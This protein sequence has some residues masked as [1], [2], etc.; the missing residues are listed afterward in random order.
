MWKRMIDLEYLPLGHSCLTFLSWNDARRNFRNH[1]VLFWALLHLTFPLK[2]IHF[3]HATTGRDG[4]IFIELL[5]YW[6]AQL[7][8][9]YDANSRWIQRIKGRRHLIPKKIKWKEKKK[10]TQTTLWRWLTIHLTEDSKSFNIN[11]GLWPAILLQFHDDLLLIFFLLFSL[12]S[13]FRF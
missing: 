4:A 9:L 6:S 8:L 12:S 3:N 5:F 13:D 7:K 11:S 1:F 10:D 2:N